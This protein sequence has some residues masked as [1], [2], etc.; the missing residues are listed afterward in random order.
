MAKY[1]SSE[2]VARLWNNVKT[3]V[4]NKFVPKEEGKGLSAN[5]YTTAEKQKLAGI[6]TGAQANKIEGIKVNGQAITPTDKVV[7][8]KVLVAKDLADYTEQVDAKISAIPKFAI[9]VAEK[10]PTEN[11]SGTTVYLIKSSDDSQNLYTEYI[12]VNSEWEKLGTQTVDLSNYVTK[13]NAVSGARA[14]DA[15][16]ITFTKADGT[17]F[18]VVITGT[19]YGKATAEADGLMS[20]E[21]KAK[22]DGVAENANNYV[23]P[24]TSGNKH[25]PAGGKSGQI[26]GWTA[27]GTAVWRDE[28]DTSYSVFKPATAEAAGGAGLVPAPAAGNDDALLCG[29]GTWA[30]PMTNEEIDAICV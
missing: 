20:K 10:L 26:L 28:S 15:K 19:T 11:I 6:E 5:D 3:W 18:D 13:T 27:D 25:I 4:Q 24:T 12:Y 1:L 7:N 8:L 17:T 21:D 16:T 30:E 2:Q 29:D 22:L 14:K 9:S 23:H